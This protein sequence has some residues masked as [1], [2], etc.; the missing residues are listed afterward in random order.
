LRPTFYMEVWLSPLSGFDSANA[1]ATVFGRGENPISWISFHDVARLAALCVGNPAAQH[2][3]FELGGPEALTPLDV[4]R[5]FEQVEGRAFH[6]EYISA[7]A[8]A[9]QQAAARDSYQQSLAGLKRCYADGD[10]IDMSRTLTLFPIRLTSVRGYT[11]SV[12]HPA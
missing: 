8:L 2:R 11:M 9:E 12:V 10:V 5:L 7:D 1:R 4:I 3:T 6:V